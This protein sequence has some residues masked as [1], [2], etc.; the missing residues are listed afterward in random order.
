MMSK[1]Q[2]AG[3]QLAALCVHHSLFIAVANYALF[4][5]I[6]S[7]ISCDRLPLELYTKGDS[8]VNITCKMD[9]FTNALNYYNLT[10]RQHFRI[11]GLSIMYAKDGDSINI[12]DV[13]HNTDYKVTKEDME[14]GHYKMVVMTNTIDEYVGNMK[15]FNDKDY[16][17]MYAVSETYNIT[18]RN[19]W[20]AGRQYMVEPLPIGVAVDSFDVTMN[21]DGR[22]FYEYNKSGDGFH[23]SQDVEYEMR[24]MTT[25]LHI[26]VKVRNINYL[27][28]PEMGG[29]DGYVTGLADG[30][31][32]TKTW[33]RTETGDIKLN[34]W[35]TESIEGSRTRASDPGGVGWIATDIETFGLPHGRELVTQRS[36]ASNYLKLHFTLIDGNTVDF[37]YNVGKMLRYTFDDGSPYATIEPTQ[38]ALHLDLEIDAPFMTDDEVPI[39]PYA[40][41][42]G[43]GAFDA[44]VSPWGDEENV[45]IPM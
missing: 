12:T 34:H 32:F 40:Q 9:I 18:D 16:N 29:V 26:R 28:S 4:T 30:F 13:T 31:Y 8:Q 42:K 14:N 27:L 45:D 11:N 44:E 35:Y 33:R 41:P 37:S 38:L 5:I 23:D 22:V 24:P 20:D 7:L 2:A 25:T 43:T 10:H 39:M 3:R 15:F 21:N 1:M 36:E 17:N 19:A 6:Y